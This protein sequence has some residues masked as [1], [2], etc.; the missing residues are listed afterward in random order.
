M[1][2]M[3]VDERGGVV[4]NNRKG[5]IRMPVTAALRHSFMKQVSNLMAL[6]F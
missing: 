3:Q 4:F 2:C 1:V 6:L 5:A